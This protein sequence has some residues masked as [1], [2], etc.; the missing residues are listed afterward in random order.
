MF[1][2]FIIRTKSILVI[3]VCL[4]LELIHT[5]FIHHL[6]KWLREMS[7]IH[8]LSLKSC[9]HVDKCSNLEWVSRLCCDST[10]KLLGPFPHWTITYFTLSHHVYMEM[11]LK[12]LH[13][14]WIDRG[15]KHWV[16]PSYL[17]PDCYSSLCFYNCVCSVV[18]N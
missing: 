8:H 13:F 14:S 11:T 6:G 9:N 4:A 17:A 3:F 7:F 1:F 16:Q 5:F 12:H 15:K 2:L 18:M 10:V